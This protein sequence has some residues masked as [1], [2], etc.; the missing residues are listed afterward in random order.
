MRCR[1]LRGLRTG[2][3]LQ[4]QMAGAAVVV[5][6]LAL[7]LDC[8]YFWGPSCLE[9]EMAMVGEPQTPVGG[10]GPTYLGRA[11]GAALRCCGLQAR[12]SQDALVKC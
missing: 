9:L 7:G 2:H 3:S 4:P 5:H 11:E 12:Q 10:A 6:E 1:R 8:C